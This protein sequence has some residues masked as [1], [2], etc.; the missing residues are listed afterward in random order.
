MKGFMERRLMMDQ[1]LE[2]KST[3][4]I[5]KELAILIKAKLKTCS[6]KKEE[7]NAV[8]L[9]RQEINTKYGK[10]WRDRDT[11]NSTSNNTKYEE[12]SIY[13]GHENGQYWMD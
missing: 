7:N 3:K 8:E 4:K 12:P 1:S 10:G 2:K 6:T 9:A 13:D 11:F 5:R